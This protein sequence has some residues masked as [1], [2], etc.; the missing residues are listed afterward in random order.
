ME[1]IKNIKLPIILVDDE[2]EILFSSRTQLN[3]AG[4]GPV[5]SMQDGRKLIP[6]LEEFGGAMIILDLMMPNITGIELLPQL[7]QR[8]PEI[9]VVVMTATHDLNRAVECMKAGAFDYM[10]KPVENS[11]FISCVKRA[12]ELRSLRSEVGLLKEVLFSDSAQNVSAFD[13]I[14][15]RSRKMQ[16]IFRYGEAIA[17]SNEPVLVIGDTGVGKELL[18]EALHKVSNRKGALVPLNVAGLDDTMFSD[19]LFGHRKGAFSGADLNREGLIAKA[20]KGT[21]FLD[22]IGDLKESSQIK[23]LRLLQERRYYPLGADGAIGTDARIICATNKNLKDLMLAD[24]FRADLY[25]RLSAHQI[26]I[27]PLRER[28]EDIILLA[29]RFINDAAQSM[30]KKAP[31]LPPELFQLLNAYD[32]PGNIRELR[33]MIFDGVAMHESGSLSLKS[34]Q[35][36][37]LAKKSLDATLPLPD[38]NPFLAFSGRLP[39]F[40][41]AEYILIEAAIQR[42]NGNKTLAASLLGITRQTLNN[43]L[44][45]KAARKQT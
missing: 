38:E 34:F 13:H 19:T 39:T 10:L 20:A 44:R 15:T 2:E 24:K 1:S 26:T 41:E 9:P 11:R 5:E 23:L 17:N 43:R 35:D 42:S 7:T 28:R 6:F 4:M 27:P 16:T 14:I 29:N 40:A 21:L 32:F 22:E 30:G 37:V 3:F 8:F 12:L 31:N 25:F 45:K 33:A 18:V 36:I